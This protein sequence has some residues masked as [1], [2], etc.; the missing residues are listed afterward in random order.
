M[1]TVGI[2]AHSLTYTESIPAR[3]IDP[4]ALPALP[5]VYVLW[6]E[7]GKLLYAGL[8]GVRWSADNPRP[9]STLARRLTDH[10]DARR[11]DV[12]T[13][14]LFERCVAP[15]LTLS[16]LQA[17]GAGELGLRDL[18]R[19]FLHSMTRVGWLV[20]P[21]YASARATEDAIRSGMLGQK[22]IINPL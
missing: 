13:S 19:Q 3:E 5:G 16:D 6:A 18:V 8:A 11:A 7:P 14:Y 1:A 15:N 21:D 12:L 17:M 10:L 22:P 9:A 20:T 2:S 4:R